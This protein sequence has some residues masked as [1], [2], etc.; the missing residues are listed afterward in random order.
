MPVGIDPLALSVAAGFGLLTAAVFALWPIGKAVQ[1]KAG[2]LFRAMIQPPPGLPA[3]AVLTG[4][5]AGL[6]GLVALTLWISN[7]QRVAVVFVLGVIGAVVV[8][9]AGAWVLGA[10]LRDSGRGSGRACRRFW[11]R[12]WNRF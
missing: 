12:F 9:R 4:I 6:V 3:A 10:V 11:A 1:I 8:F 5:G 2:H 7:D